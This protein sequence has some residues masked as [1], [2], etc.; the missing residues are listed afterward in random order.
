MSFDPSIF[1]FSLISEN[2]WETIPTNMGIVGSY[3]LYMDDDRWDLKE[4]YYHNHN[5][6]EHKLYYG[7]IPTNEFAF[8]LFK[9]LELELPIINRDVII[10][11][12]LK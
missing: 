9:N 4:I 7:K 2:I 11:E 10:N 8:E 12:I 3:K 5:A 1:H 6:R